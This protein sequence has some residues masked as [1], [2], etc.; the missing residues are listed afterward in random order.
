MEFATSL[1]SSASTALA[2]AQKSTLSSTYTTDPSTAP[3]QI[4]VWKIT[5][6][7]HNSNNKQVSIW[8]CDKGSLVSSSSSSSGFS[9][10]ASNRRDR[11]GDRLKYAIDTL[12]KE[13]SS[14]SRLRHP[15]V[16]EM[17][18]PPNESRSSITFAT[19]P[20]LSSLQH[21]LE[22]STRRNKS[23]QEEELELDEVEIQKG[24]SQLGKGLGFLHESA[25][26]VHGNLT[27]EAVII[28]A[29]GDWKLSGFG[30]STYLFDAEGVPAKWQFPV[31]DPSL[32]RSIQRDYDYIAPEYI[33][34]ESS[35]APA[36]D[37]YSLGCILHSIHLRTGPPFANHNTLSTARS[38]IE[39]SL[40]LLTSQWRKLPQET[41]QVLNSLIT[42]Y[43]NRRMTAKQFL[44]SSYFE[45]VLVGTLRFLERDSFNSKPG[46]VQAS[47]LKGLITVLPSFSSKVNRLKILPTLLELTVQSNLIPF[48]LPPILY[49]ATQLPSQDFTRDVLPNLKPLFTVKEPVQAVV[50]LLDN[51]NVFKEKCS[52]VVF[53]EE[54]MPLVYHALESENPVVLEKALRVVPGLCETL[55]Y[56]T[57]KQTLFPKITTVFSKTTLLS[58]KVNTLICFHSMIKIL[59]KFT[60]TEKLVPLLSKIKTKEPSV[61]IATLA[62][63]EE[64]GKKCEVEAI[65]TLIL[66]QLWAMSIG[67]LLNVDQFTKFITVIKSLSARVE[68]EHFQRLSELKRLEESSGGGRA[69]SANGAGGGG[70]GLGVLN[71]EA[72][73]VSDFEALVRGTTNSTTNGLGARGKQVDIFSDESPALT[74]TPTG[75]N[76]IFSSPPLPALPTSSPPFVSPSAFPSATP[77]PSLQ[78]SR[79]SPA[80]RTSS[81]HSTSALP[82]S[83][84]GARSVPSSSFNS[85]VFPAQSSAAT[86]APQQNSLR[87]FAPLQPQSRTSP[88]S[89]PTT[90]AATSSGSTTP[91]YNFSSLSISS[92]GLPP[93]QPTS[94]SIFPASTNSYQPQPQQSQQSAPPIKWN[95]VPPLQ[96]T[97][98][99]S[100]L[101]LS[102]SQPQPRQPDF[103]PGYSSS[104]ATLQPTVR[105]QGGANG[106]ANWG[107]WKD[108]DPLK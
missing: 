70:S 48:L 35:P 60:L 19:E 81:N 21:S 56:T 63:H 33:L 100:S 53:R 37:L 31:Y 16:L 49:I 78:P 30:L 69:G 14:L 83:S 85:S 89:A 2:A 77:L 1:L 18:E 74:P 6:A 62:V 40:S 103:P 8:T 5:R 26:L 47:F 11:D 57:V 93:L 64:M 95:V 91:N 82:R 46:D 105:S 25:K 59:D 76:N 58:V 24:M 61:M 22:V 43:P 29:K 65:A 90:P 73:G 9:S 106:A 45:G 97:N 75:G 7:K 67:P 23:R 17:A 13:A 15:C 52:D 87:S 54:V 27:P 99:S 104:A 84:L 38:N 98:S 28:N 10:G 12:K 88:H 80:P 51:L 32:P 72:A 107:D 94:S 108:L 66:P 50:G 68:T 20:V 86:P 41:Q 102:A 92:S 96:P 79:P 36:N 4:G 44:E 101:P 55:D 71:P 39:S 42:R 3:I 34:D